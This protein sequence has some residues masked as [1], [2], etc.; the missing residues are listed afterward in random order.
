MYIIILN[1]TIFELYTC[2]VGVIS[3]LQGDQCA[4]NITIVNILLF[5]FTEIMFR[6]SEA[7]V[8]A[9]PG[10]ILFL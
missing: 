10:G 7:S 1:F 9:K 6:A 8:P 3:T 4:K 2:K 5:D